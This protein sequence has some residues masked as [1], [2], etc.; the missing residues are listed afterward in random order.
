MDCWQQV[1][2]MNFYDQTQRLSWTVRDGLHNQL[3][4]VRDNAA[5]P[6]Q[7][8][9]NPSSFFIVFHSWLCGLIFHHRVKSCMETAQKMTENCLC[10]D[11]KYTERI[12]KLHFVVGSGISVPAGC[13]TWSSACSRYLTI[14]ILAVLI[15]VTWLLV[16]NESVVASMLCWG[17]KNFF[18]F[19]QNVG[20]FLAHF[21]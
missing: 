8:S 19:L 3:L 17:V 4:N 20:L 21:Y 10:V 15:F 18:C 16:T 9:L 12:L 7:T 14:Y 1:G 5:F 13:K 11:I 2:S 6:F